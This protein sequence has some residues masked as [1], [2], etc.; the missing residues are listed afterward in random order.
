MKVRE[1]KPFQGSTFFISVYFISIS[2]I[3][4]CLIVSHLQ[5]KFI[6]FTNINT[7]IINVVLTLI[8]NE[9]FKC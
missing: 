9:T 3:F 7:I 1:S 6:L 4:A 5:S 8:Q 2:F